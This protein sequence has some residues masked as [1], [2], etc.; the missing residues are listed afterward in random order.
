MTSTAVP[1]SFKVIIVG[2]SISGLTLAHALHRAGIPHTVLEKRKTITFDG[3]ASISLQSNGLRILDQLGLYQDIL[4]TTAPIRVSI[5]RDSNGKVVRKSRFMQMVEERHGYPILCLERSELLDVLYEKYEKKEH[6]V[7]SSE[8][9]KVDSRR[10][11][12]V[13]STKN[14][15][16]YKGDIVVGADGIHSSIRKYMWDVERDRDSEAARKAENCKLAK[17]CSVGDIY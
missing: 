15:K 8:V 3:G 1:N 9:V 10:D 5:W 12:V 4:K 2:G 11:E 6:I 16:V 14:G 17:T 13:V 7:T